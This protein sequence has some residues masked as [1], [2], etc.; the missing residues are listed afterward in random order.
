MVKDGK[1]RITAAKLGDETRRQVKHNFA[2]TPNALFIRAALPAKRQ[3]TVYGHRQSKRRST[4]APAPAPAPA[5]QKTKTSLQFFAC[6]LLT[7]LQAALRG[8][9]CEAAQ[10]LLHQ[11]SQRFGLLSGVSVRRTS[12]CVTAESNSHARSRLT[13]V[14]LICPAVT[15]YTAIL[16]PRACARSTKKPSQKIPVVCS[17]LGP[18]WQLLHSK[19][20]SFL[21]QAMSWISG[22]RHGRCTCSSAR[23]L[24]HLI[25]DKLA[26]SG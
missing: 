25:L 26:C 9:A 10:I 17:T 21:P 12:K 13:A 5:T 18:K 20:G 3:Q 24:A 15:C 8:K 11:S 1:V 6:L 16:R 2:A 22:E 7:H 19:M 23:P 4:P 14:C